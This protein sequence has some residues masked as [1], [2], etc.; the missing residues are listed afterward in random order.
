[1]TA[2]LRTRTGKPGGYILIFSL[3]LLSVVPGLK[4]QG[5]ERIVS[6]TPSLTMNIYYLES[7][8]K[9]VGCTSYC[10]IAKNDSIPVV[11]SA[12]KANIEKIVS[13]KPDLVIVTSLMGPETTDMLNKFGIKVEVFPSPK[14]FNE[15]CSQF[16]RI[17]KLLDKEALA[18]EIIRQSTMEVKK[19]QS[20]CH[21]KNSPDIF[22][23]LGTKPLFA[24]IPDTFMDDY[25]RFINGKNITGDLKTGTITREV[26]IAR[27]PDVIFIVTMG[28]LAEEEKNNWMDINSMKASQ[29]GCIFIIDSN[30]ACTPTPVSFVN[31]LRTI[32][33]LLNNNYNG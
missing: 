11:A 13:L 15:I 9:L 3:T 7:Q 27:D 32:V 10:E 12:V 18:S 21:W 26:V 24:V 23:Q 33:E 29:T 19:L 8:D 5:Y 25:I 2:L 16:L 31:T 14:S 4:G 1:M 20:D 17:G 30:M 6:L 28:I 22:I